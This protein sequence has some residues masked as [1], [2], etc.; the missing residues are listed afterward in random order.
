MAET[1]DLPGVLP[2]PAQRQLQKALAQV[3]SHFRC[4]Q[5]WQEYY[6]RA[7]GG[8]QILPIME[9]QKAQAQQDS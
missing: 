4:L 9:T 8:M 2:G 5:M 6:S 3:P 1:L 7:R